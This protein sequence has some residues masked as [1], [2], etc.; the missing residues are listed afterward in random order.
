MRVRSPEGATT[1]EHAPGATLQTAHEVAELLEQSASA[2]PQ[3]PP[4]HEE[5]LAQ[6]ALYEASKG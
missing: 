2:E 5:V 6:V 3:A 4:S 1:I